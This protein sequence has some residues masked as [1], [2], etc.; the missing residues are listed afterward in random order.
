MGL[1]S[2]LK[3]FMPKNR[4]FFELF[5]QVAD[6]VAKMGTIMKDVVAETDFDKRAALISQIED[7]EHANDELT[8]SVFTELGRNFITP[9]DREDIH[10]LATSLLK[11]STSTALTRMIWACRKWQN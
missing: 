10:Y 7:L 3:I 9:F 5:E 11:R 1:N 8:H 4:V 2:F 6:N